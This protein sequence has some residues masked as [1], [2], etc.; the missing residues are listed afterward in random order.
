MHLVWIKWKRKS[1]SDEWD[2]NVSLSTW[3]SECT[4][5]GKHSLKA[6]LPPF[7]KRS[8]ETVF[9]QKCALLQERICSLSEKIYVVPNSLIMQRAWESFAE[10]SRLITTTQCYKATTLLPS[11]SLLWKKYIAGVQIIIFQSTR[12]TIPYLCGSAVTDKRTYPHSVV[13]ILVIL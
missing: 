3:R 1:V 13:R 7:W 9:S 10:V 12:A 2:E 6:I 11:K 5:R 8:K 4:F